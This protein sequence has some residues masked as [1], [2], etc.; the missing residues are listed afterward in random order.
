MLTSGGVWSSGL[1][2][3]NWGTVPPTQDGDVDGTIEGEAPIVETPNRLWVY[4]EV[5]SD[6]VPLRSVVLMLCVRKEGVEVVMWG[7]EDF[8]ADGF[9]SAGLRALFRYSDKLI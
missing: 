7:G 8:S 3:S 5:S 1:T 4:V 9:R 6:G 2:G